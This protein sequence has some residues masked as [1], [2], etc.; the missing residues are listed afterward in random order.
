M[1][2]VVPGKELLTES[3]GVLEATERFIWPAFCSRLYGGPTQIWRAA[4][5][6]GSLAARQIDLFL[7]KEIQLSDEEFDSLFQQLSDDELDRR[8][9]QFKST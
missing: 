5:G 1:F 7:Q 4:S 8:I 2:V 3:A 9:S 6:L